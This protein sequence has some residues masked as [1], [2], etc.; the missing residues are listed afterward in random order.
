[1]IISFPFAFGGGGIKEG[2]KETKTNC[3]HSQCTLLVSDGA[4]VS[5]K[6]LQTSEFAASA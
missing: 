5:I 4:E 3:R 6:R 2:R 1:M